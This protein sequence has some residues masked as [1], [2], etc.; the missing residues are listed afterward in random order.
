[1]GR[2]LDRT[3]PADGHGT[4]R[5]DVGGLYADTALHSDIGDLDITCGINPVQLHTHDLRSL[6]S[7]VDDQAQQLLRSRHQLSVLGLGAIFLM[8]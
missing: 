6:R 8:W 4:A 5:S 7:L 2:L 1:M 3:H